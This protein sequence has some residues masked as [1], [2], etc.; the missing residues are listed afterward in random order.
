MLDRHVNTT[1]E[2]I[3]GVLDKT[4]CLSASW[5]LIAHLAFGARVLQ[6]VLTISVALG[7]RC[8][9]FSALTTIWAK[10]SLNVWIGQ[11]TTRGVLPHMLAHIIELVDVGNGARHQTNIAAN[12]A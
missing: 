1:R 6:V 9:L 2:S 8:L 10:S 5:A 4:A 7:T 11:R 12:L 3:S